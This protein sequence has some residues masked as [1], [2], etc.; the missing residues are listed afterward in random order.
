MD[1]K[2]PKAVLR[3]TIV[4]AA[5]NGGSIA[6][7]SPNSFG[8]RLYLYAKRINYES[9]RGNTENKQS[10]QTIKKCSTVRDQFRGF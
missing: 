3:S 5:G 7:V 4:V 10:G 6:A 2:A 9:S 1:G 8:Y